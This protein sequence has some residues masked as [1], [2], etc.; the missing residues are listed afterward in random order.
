VWCRD[1]YKLLAKEADV[2]LARQPHLPGGDS[3]S[4]ASS[5]GN[6]ASAWDVT[7]AAAAAG[8]FSALA[9]DAAAADGVLQGVETYTVHLKPMPLVRSGQFHLRTCAGC[10]MCWS[11]GSNHMIP[12]VWNSCRHQLSS[13]HASTWAHVSAVSTSVQSCCSICARSCV[14][15]PHNRVCT[16][17]TRSITCKPCAACVP[18]GV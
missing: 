6:V 4:S 1:V 11:A 15:Q 9:G 12:A 7:D 16:C 13:A 3:A 5:D 17:F 10:C 18:A 2:T 8:M 14:R